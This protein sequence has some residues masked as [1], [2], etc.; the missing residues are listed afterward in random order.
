MSLLEFA[1]WAPIRTEF[2]EM[3]VA[4]LNPDDLFFVGLTERYETDLTHLAELLDWQTRPRITM[5]NVN[6]SPRST[7][8]NTTRARIG[9]LHAVEM[10]WYHRFA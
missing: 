1:E 8:D 2:A 6:E 4:G 10:D 9:E 7:V 3:Y 5:A